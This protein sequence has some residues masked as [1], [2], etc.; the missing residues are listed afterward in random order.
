[1]IKNLLSKQS[2]VKNELDCSSVIVVYSSKNGS[3]RGFVRPY[4][5][6]I[7]TETRNQAI[8]ALKDMLE[9]YRNMLKKYNYPE[10]LQTKPFSDDEDRSFF[11]KIA[12]EALVGK[13]KV[14]TKSFYAE[15]VPA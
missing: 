4:D 12:L 3:W 8:E 9:T 2:D 14:N 15:A 13:G 10:H 11:D 7:E 6:T 5:I 1:M